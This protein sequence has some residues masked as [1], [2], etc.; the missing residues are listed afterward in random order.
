M[1]QATVSIER[2]MRAKPLYGQFDLRGF[3]NT[4]HR[5]L[6][7]R[8]LAE[9]LGRRL[10]RAELQLIAV[11]DALNELIVGQL[12]EV[13]EDEVIE[14]VGDLQLRQSPILPTVHQPRLGSNGATNV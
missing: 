7:G 6:L 14:S 11:G 2:I 10:T 9:R 1:S 13:E 4:A 8:K 3:H 12:G 5:I